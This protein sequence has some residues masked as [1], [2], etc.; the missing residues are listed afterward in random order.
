MRRLVMFLVDFRYFSHKMSL[1]D[2]NY[3]HDELSL[4]I[5]MFLL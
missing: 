1:V 5:I 4:L 2:E 3:V